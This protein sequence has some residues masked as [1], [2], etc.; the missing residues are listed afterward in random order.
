MPCSEELPRVAAHRLLPAAQSG[1]PQ[2]T[3]LAI[4]YP[5]DVAAEAIPVTRFQKSAPGL[6]LCEEASRWQILP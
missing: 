4:P 5:D 2:H 6:V 1:D 3:I